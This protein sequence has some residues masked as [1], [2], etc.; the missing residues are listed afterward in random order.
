MSEQLVTSEVSSPEDCRRE[1]EWWRENEENGADEVSDKPKFEIPLKRKRSEEEEEEEDEEDGHEVRPE[2]DDGG[3]GFKTPTRPENR[4][5]EIGECP[6]APMKDR[7]GLS[8]FSVIKR[9]SCRR[10]LEF[11][12][13]DMIGSFFTDLQKTAT[14]R[15]T[16]EADDGDT[17]VRV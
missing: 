11:L 16:V 3:D 2:V 4:V 5:P 10:R 12:P 1:E 14:K 6:A 13:E 15:M 8:A 9:G 17:I 7:P